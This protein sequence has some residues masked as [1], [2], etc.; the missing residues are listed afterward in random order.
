[1]PIGP[2]LE[3]LLPGQKKKDD[4]VAEDKL[5]EK[6][7]PDTS[8]PNLPWFNLKIIP[9]VVKGA[10]P[11]VKQITSTLTGGHTTTVMHNAEGTLAFKSSEFDKLGELP[12]TK[13]VAVRYSEG[14]M[15]LD[16]G[17]IIHDY[18]KGDKQK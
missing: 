5:K 17:E 6:I 4:G 15:V 1:M 11:D 16:Y 12:V 13:I 7:Q 3:D 18:L 9:S 14:D 8:T 2:S 10:L